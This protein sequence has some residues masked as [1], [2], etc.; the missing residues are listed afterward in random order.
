MDYSQATKY[1][2]PRTVRVML[3]GALSLRRS[4]VGAR[5]PDRTTEKG[6]FPFNAPLP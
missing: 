4:N 5:L 6:G 2:S 1:R 3:A